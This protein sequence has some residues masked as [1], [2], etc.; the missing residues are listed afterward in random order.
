MD[1]FKEHENPIVV[2]GA[3]NFI[4]SLD[5][6]LLRAG[7]LDKKIEVPSPTVKGRKEILSLYLK[8]SKISSGLI[9]KKKENKNF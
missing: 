1:G 7:R 5:S 9:S 8:K 4:D 6:A 3:T 2:I